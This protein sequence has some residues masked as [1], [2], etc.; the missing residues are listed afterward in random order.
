MCVYMLCTCH[1][2]IIILNTYLPRVEAVWQA[3]GRKDVD[4]TDRRTSTE[5]ENRYKDRDTR[6][7][8]CSSSHRCDG[9]RGLL[10]FEICMLKPFPLFQRFCPP[11]PEAAPL[12]F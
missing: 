6:F 4:K 10:M 1:M 9:R 8:D 11:V 12:I 2:Y 3:E 7:F 5:T